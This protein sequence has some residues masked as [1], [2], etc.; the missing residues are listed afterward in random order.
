MEIAVEFDKLTGRCRIVTLTSKSFDDEC[1][2]SDVVE[3][4]GLFEVFPELKVI[5]SDRRRNE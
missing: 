2:L 5:N 3:K 1:Q 4:F